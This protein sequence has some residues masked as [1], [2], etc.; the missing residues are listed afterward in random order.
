MSIA[1]RSPTN[2]F[3][4]PHYLVARDITITCLSIVIELQL[5]DNNRA[6]LAIVLI[7]LYRYQF[8][9]ILINKFLRQ[10]NINCKIN[11]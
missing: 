1:I 3:T 9:S 7:L 8:S 4:L 5:Y 6:I 11:I 10:N 2:C